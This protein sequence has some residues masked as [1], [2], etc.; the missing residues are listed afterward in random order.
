MP[1]EVAIA[2]LPRGLSP[3][4]VRRAVGTVLQGER[5]HA[6]FSFTFLGPTAMERL[7]S[8]HL[9]RRRPTDVIAFALPT[10]A[11]LLG[12]I[13][14]CRAIAAEEARRRNIPL[15]EELVR[16]VIH[17]VLHVLGYDHP[18]SR[19]RETSAMWRKQERYLARPLRAPRP[20]KAGRRPAT[21]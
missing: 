8:R 17:G 2:R 12:D 3:V 19:G 16:L 1:D 10:G 13:Y 4:L 18:E 6:S 7:N 9:R 5:K 21:L 14:L 11:G 15:R 20:L